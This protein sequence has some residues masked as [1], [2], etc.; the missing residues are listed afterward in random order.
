MRRLATA[1]RPLGWWAT[2]CQEGQGGE[3]G[4]G[5]GERSE[6]GGM[7]L[8]GCEARAAVRTEEVVSCCVVL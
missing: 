7:G 6:G 8:G 2:T 4:G 1:S 5:C 3:R